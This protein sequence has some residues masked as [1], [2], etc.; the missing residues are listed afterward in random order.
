[1]FKLR[2]I[3]SKS[4]GRKK[5]GK[6]SPVRKKRGKKSRSRS[7]SSKK[8]IK[9]KNFMRRK[10]S[11]QRNSHKNTN[12]DNLGLGPAKGFPLKTTSKNKWEDYGLG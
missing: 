2:S 5:R 1:M 3:R 8:T 7:N 4:P 10:S 11:P 12:W 6:K 9:L